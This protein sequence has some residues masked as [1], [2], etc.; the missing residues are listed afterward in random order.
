MCFTLECPYLFLLVFTTTFNTNSLTVNVTTKVFLLI[1]GRAYC[2]IRI[3]Y[4]R[5]WWNKSQKV[6][7]EHWNSFW[8]TWNCVG[9]QCFAIN[10]KW[11]RKK[12]NTKSSGGSLLNS[13]LIRRDLSWRQFCTNYFKVFKEFT[14][15]KDW[16][17]QGK[18]SYA[19]RQFKI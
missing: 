15:L 16:L 18:H 12:P 2:I 4:S 7:E 8:L 17:N 1:N 9:Y 14:K 3:Y 13:R 10:L 5:N 6:S 11:S 19:N